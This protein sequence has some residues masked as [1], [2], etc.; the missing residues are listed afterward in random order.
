MSAAPALLRWTTRSQP[1]VS[2]R[3]RATSIGTSV[4]AQRAA[5]E[6]AGALTGLDEHL[7]VHDRRVVAAAALHVAT[8]AVREVVHVLGQ[9]ER[10]RVDVEHVDV[11]VRARPQH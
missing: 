4:A 5:G 9:W 2:A 7:A 8:R 1:G 3:A 11:G 10:E 6:R